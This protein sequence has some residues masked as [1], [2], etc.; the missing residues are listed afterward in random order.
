MT[1]PV[2]W[3]GG[4]SAAGK[5]TVARTLAL[6]F[7]LGFYRIDARAY[8]HRDRMIRRG[9]VPDG[10]PKSYDERWLIPTPDQIAQ[11]FQA[12]SALHPA[13]IM[14]D[15]A[16]MAD[17]VLTIVE[18]P[19][20]FR[21]DIAEFWSG[22]ESALWLLS[23][24]EFRRA[25]LTARS[26]DAS[27]FT[28]DARKAMD[29]RIARDTILSDRIRREAGDAV[30]EVDGTRD[31]STMVDLVGGYF[32]EQI[33]VGP[34]IAD[35]AMRQRVRRFENDV[36]VENV[37]AF[38]AELGS[39]APAVFAPLPF[40]C[41]CDRLGCELLVEVALPQYEEARVERRDLLAHAPSPR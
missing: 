34:R 38:R 17:P 23:T 5:T 26:G 10:P 15:L 24:E 22:P 28:S 8:A 1:P 14:E 41:E 12:A 4:S 33:A 39:R 37:R 13:L 31:L 16:A 3:L 29:K 2:L 32:R 21:D 30:F 11:E 9:L 36:M 7:D 6:R 27:R 19:Q 35:G 20:L 18:G 25:A 40:T